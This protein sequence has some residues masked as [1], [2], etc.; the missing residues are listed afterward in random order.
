MDPAE[1]TPRARL[2]AHMGWANTLD[3]SARTAPARQAAET[4][5][6]TKAREMHPH[7]TD[8]QIA[9]VA[10]SLRKAH[11]AALGLRSAQARRLKRAERT[12]RN[13]EPGDGR[14]G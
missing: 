12:I 9:A 8:S 13:A 10:E 2:A 7:A 11:Y 4:R 3:R 1:H 5:F 14:E 6:E